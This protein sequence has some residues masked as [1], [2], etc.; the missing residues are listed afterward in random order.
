MPAVSV[1]V[2]CFNGAAYLEEALSCVVAQTFQDWEVVF[3]DNASTD[4][5]P[6]IAQ[7]FGEKV[8]CFRASETSPL[9]AARNLALAESRGEL[10]AFLDCDDLW[11]PD[12]LRKQVALF[13]A[14]PALGLACTDTVVF[15]GRRELSRMFAGGR[16]RRG[17][18][19]EALIRDQWISMSS[20]MIRRSALE[21]LEEWFDP[22]LSLCEEADL[23]Y[24]LAK[25]WEVDFVDEPLTRWRVHG[26]NTTFRRFERFAEETRIILE[27]HRRI[28][29]EYDRLYPDSVAVLTRRAAFQQA[30]ALWRQGRGAEA[31]NLLA[32]HASGLKVRAF[33]LASRLPGSWF[34][35]LSRLYFAL[36]ALFRR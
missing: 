4:E 36:P 25:D 32:P 30:V 28:Y 8:R 2:N 34:E 23:F 20:A 3:W 22:T 31:R 14:N 19:F 29:P 35:P 24:R 1:I 17:R 26:I 33:C 15:D 11:L 10:I 13:E 27:K 16:A 9:G 6:D 5:S 12:K 7:R 18:V 21:S